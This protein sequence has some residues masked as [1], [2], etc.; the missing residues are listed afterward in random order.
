M[1]EQEL[2]DLMI[3]EKRLSIIHARESRKQLHLF[4][5]LY[6]I[7]ILLLLLK[8]YNILLLV[9]CFFWAR[10]VDFRILEQFQLYFEEGFRFNDYGL[11]TEFDTFKLKYQRFK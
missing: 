10:Q 8:F 5:L 6:T 3:L 9:P 2:K 1:K 4:V 7:A 11:Q